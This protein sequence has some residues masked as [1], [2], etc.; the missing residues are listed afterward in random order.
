MAKKKNRA[1][2]EI[3]VPLEEGFYLEGD[4]LVCVVPA[5]VDDPQP[6]GS[7]KTLLVASTGGKTD[8][9]VKGSP[10]KVNVNAF[11]PNPDKPK[12]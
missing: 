7:G 6:S 12:G 11:I 5:E 1:P 4:F 3:T 10:L 2:S 9:K 8:L